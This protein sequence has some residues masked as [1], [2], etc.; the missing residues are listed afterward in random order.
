VPFARRCICRSLQ[1]FT[2]ALMDACRNSA[3]THVGLAPARSLWVWFQ[4]APLI[5]T[6][7][8]HCAFALDAGLQAPLLNAWTHCDNARQ[9]AGAAKG[10]GWASVRDWLALGQGGRVLLVLENVEDVLRHGHQ[11]LPP[12]TCWHTALPPPTCWHTSLPPPTCWHTSLP[13]PT[14]WHT[15][16]PP[17]TCWHTA[18]P[19]PTCWHTAPCILLHV[20]CLAAAHAR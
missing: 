18:L 1:L 4:M 7:I 8:G 15:S 2:L 6:G 3:T 17:P 9:A 19:P 5:R 16:L 11:A 10:Q 13:P 12:P 14:C 20:C